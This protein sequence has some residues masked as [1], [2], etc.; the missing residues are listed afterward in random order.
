MGE[1]AEF[2]KE[3]NKEK[4]LSEKIECGIVPCD[5]KLHRKS[6]KA[7]DVREAVRRLKQ[8]TEEGHDDWN[9]STMLKEIDE[10]FGE[11]LT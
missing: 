1:T 11:A 10:I 4:S 5:E 9:L 7:T 3:F 6:L 2:V 8:A